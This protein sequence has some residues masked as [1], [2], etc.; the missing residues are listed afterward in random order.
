MNSLRAISAALVIGC[1]INSVYATDI[2]L[3][4]E[5]IQ[6][7]QVGYDWTFIQHVNGI[8]ISYSMIELN[9]ERFLS[10]QFENTNQ[11]DVDFIWSMTKNNSQIRITADEMIESRVQLT[12]NT[13][14]IVDGIYLIEMTSDDQFSDFVVSIQPT[15]H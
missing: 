4:K 10:I 12:S 7:D 8:A 13:S 14:E 5:L 11:N 1:S 2:E 3:P 9:D 15:K 6:H